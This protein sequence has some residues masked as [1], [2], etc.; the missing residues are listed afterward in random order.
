MYKIKSFN[1]DPLFLMSFLVLIVIGSIGILKH[2]SI[3]LALT[4]GFFYLGIKLVSG[5]QINFPRHFKLYTLFL[6]TLLIHSLFFDGKI[7]YFWM[8]LSGG[9]FWLI[10][11]NNLSILNNWLL[12]FSL[13]FGFLMAATSIILK[14]NGVYFMSPDNLFLPL[15]NW[16]QHNHLGDLWAIILIPVIYKLV[17]KIDYKYIIILLVGIAIIATSSSRSAIFA[18][19]A[20][21]VLLLTGLSEDAAVS[22]QAFLIKKR[23]N[24]ILFFL[25]GVLIYFSLSKS[26][27]ASRPY[28]YEAILGTLV[29]PLGNGIGNFGL[30]TNSTNIVHNLVLEVLLGLGIFSFIFFIWLYKIFGQLT[31][32]PIKNPAMYAM[33]LG[34]FV[35]FFFDS[36]YVIPGMLWF[37]FLLLAFV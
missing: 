25:G 18:L 34:F 3:P 2:I 20:G 35:N 5:T 16:V 14:L 31:S 30:I 7:V 19:A 23:L 27:F 9:L 11:F 4:L 37:S 28:F 6:L 1:V 32:L 22:K 26:I 10:A 13:I 8:F 12:Y 36:T 21:T 15:E 33:W 29:H 17:K 24:I